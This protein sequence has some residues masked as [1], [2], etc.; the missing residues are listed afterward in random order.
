MFAPEISADAIGAGGV[1]CVVVVQRRLCP[2][3]AANPV[4]SKNALAMGTR[5]VSP[6]CDSGPVAPN[7]E[8][9]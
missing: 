7:F 6:E 9:P 5:P 1:D 3:G 8:R 4:G 2:V